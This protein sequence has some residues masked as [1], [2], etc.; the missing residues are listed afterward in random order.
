MSDA[1]VEA[2]TI[3]AEVARRRERAAPQDLGAPLGD[4]KTP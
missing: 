4:A 1:T 3:G 2:A